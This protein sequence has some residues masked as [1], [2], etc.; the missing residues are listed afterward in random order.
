MLAPAAWRLVAA[1]V[2][3]TVAILADDLDPRVRAVLTRYLRFTATELA[4]LERGR[5]VK[6]GLDASAPGEVAV[7]GA[8]KVQVAKAVFLD[9]L[10]DIARF[11]RGPEVLQIGRFSNPPALSD[12][13][14]LTVD[15]G[16]FNPRACRVG[17]C[18]VRLAA[19]VIRRLPREVDL[20]APDAQR[21][22]SIWFKQVLLEQVTAYVTGASRMAEYDDGTRAIRPIQ[23]FEGILAGSAAIDALA[24]G[25]RAHL[26]DFPAHRVP[27]A[28]DFLYWSKEKLGSSPF[29]TVTHVTIT[30]PAATLCV[31]ATKDVYSSRYMDASL[32]F[33]IASDVVGSTSALYLV[34]VNRSRANALKGFFSGLRRAIVERRARASLEEN[35]RQIKIRL[36]SG[37]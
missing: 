12:L 4:E 29:I 14:R 9:R 15:Q 18:D 24:P 16:D 23:E 17:D 37:G 21:R 32:A 28:E 26:R 5:V 22:A 13:D 35:L 25:L 3:A 27:D 20:A 30:C 31:I 1:V 10:R 36:E 6:H 33:S 8:V 2:V 19:D 11:K 7:A 34:Y